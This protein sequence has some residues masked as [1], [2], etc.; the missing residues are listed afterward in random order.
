MNEDENDFVGYVAMVN[1]D[2]SK[3][4]PGCLSS[5]ITVVIVMVCTICVLAIMFGD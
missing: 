1:D 5:F 3:S 2:G 4:K